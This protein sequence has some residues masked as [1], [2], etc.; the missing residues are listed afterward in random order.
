MQGAV[1][2]RVRQ[3]EIDRKFIRENKTCVM[4]RVR[5][6][7]VILGREPRRLPLCRRCF[8]NGFE[9]DQATGARS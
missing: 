8:E 5:P 6:S 2:L 7:S 4:C 9:F 3:N 1:Q